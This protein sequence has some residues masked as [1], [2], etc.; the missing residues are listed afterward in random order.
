MNNV[1]QTNNTSVTDKHV[2]NRIQKIN[3]KKTELMVD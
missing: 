3:T 1:V 2:Q